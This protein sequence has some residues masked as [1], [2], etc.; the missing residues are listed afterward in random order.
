VLPGS[1]YSCTKHAVTAMGE[2]ARQDLHGSGIRVTV[3]EP[4]MTD[5]P[6]FDQ[7][8]KNALSPDDIAR[9]VLYAVAQPQ[10]VDV[11]ELLVRPTAQAG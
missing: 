3:I 2:A 1:L 10:H 7:P 4:G 6:F 11:N 8:P 9:A 5:T